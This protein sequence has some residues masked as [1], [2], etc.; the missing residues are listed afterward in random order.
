MEYD[1][2]DN[3]RTLKVFRII[4]EEK[5]KLSIMQTLIN[6]T[7]ILKKFIDNNSDYMHQNFEIIERHQREIRDLKK[8]IKKME[9]KNVNKK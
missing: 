8:R 5:V 7:E 2:Q 6:N 3:G 1:I 4:K 9:R